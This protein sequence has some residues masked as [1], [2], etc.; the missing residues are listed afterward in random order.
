MSNLIKEIQARHESSVKQDT[1]FDDPKDW[2][3][4]LLETYNECRKDRGDLLEVIET[5][6]KS[7]DLCH[8]IAGCDQFNCKLDGEECP[9]ALID[10]EAR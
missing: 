2:V 7:R 4:E 10:G 6:I 8:R 1:E 3:I 5:T 9:E